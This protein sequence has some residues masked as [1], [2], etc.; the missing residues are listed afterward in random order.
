MCRGE[1]R[2]L[3]GSWKGRLGSSVDNGSEPV[4]LHHRSAAQAIW[5]LVIAGCGIETARDPDNFLVTSSLL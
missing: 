3:S 4:L 2:C 1:L 5:P